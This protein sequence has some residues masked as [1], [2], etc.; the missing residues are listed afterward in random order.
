MPDAVRSIAKGR[1]HRDLSQRHLQGGGHY[2]ERGNLHV[3]IM[4]RS[5][6]WLD[7]GTPDSMMDAANCVRILEQRQG[8]KIA[9]L[10]EIAYRLGFIDAA[11]LERAIE[12]LGR[13]GYGRYLSGV[14]AE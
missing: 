4:G 3:D 9:A 6:A 5:Y 11:G 14:L 12:K 1:R 2:L 7:T 13:S 8:F 10:E